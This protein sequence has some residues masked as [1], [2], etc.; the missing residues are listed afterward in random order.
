LL[1]RYI[2]SSELDSEIVYMTAS[3]AESLDDDEKSAKCWEFAMADSA[4]SASMNLLSSTVENL[5]VI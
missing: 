4:G 3:I 5:F 1:L 2:Y